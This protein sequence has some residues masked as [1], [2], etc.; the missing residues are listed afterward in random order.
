MNGS[1]VGSPLISVIVPVYNVARYLER[2]IDSITGQTYG[3]IEIVLVDDGSRDDSG[4]ICDRY[5][6]KDGR[7]TVIHK[8]NSGVSDARNEGIAVAHG[9]WCAFIDSDDAIAPDYLEYLYG[10]CVKYGADLSCCSF[11][12]SSDDLPSYPGPENPPEKAISGKEAC[13]SYLTDRYLYYITVTRK[14]IRM[15][16]VRSFPY[17]GG[18]NHED[19][20]VIYRYLYAA[21]RVAVSDSVKY[22]Y[23][24][25]PTSITSLAG[26]CFSDDAA[27]AFRTMY[28]YFVGLGEKDLARKSAYKY[29]AYLFDN[30]CDEAKKQL[31]AFRKENL[32]SPNVSFRHKVKTFLYR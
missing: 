23:Y 3:N 5:A 31:L 4:E 13:A 28:G 2:C 21:E 17:P 15:P 12:R 11:V 29:I 32:F 8:E 16:I 14:L 7:I 18:R 26:N 20:A 24:V 22:F 19:D 6:E 25:N 10:L 30:R 1:E 9:E 27:W